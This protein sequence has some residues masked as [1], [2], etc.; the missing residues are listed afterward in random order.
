MTYFFIRAFDVVI[1]FSALVL[2]FP[3]FL[4]VACI[5][6]FDTGSPIFCQTRMGKGKRPFTLIKFRT[7][8][9]DTKSVAT[10]L[11]SHD[12]ITT[13]GAFLRKTKIDELP[14]LINVL[15][16]EMSLVG[17]RPNLFNQHALI[18]ERDSRNIY[19][20]L[21]GITGLSQI[22]AIDMSS[23]KLLAETDQKMIET[24][25]VCNY[26]KYILMTALGSG[27]GDRIRKDH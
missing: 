21:P 19:S 18:G 25:S 22:N 16:G 15:R 24:M 6:Y 13:Y 10:H 12:S 5:G 17:P 1:A 23:P 2:G 3:V 14:Q 27:S 11:A 4:I 8:V 7:M 26:F 9:L 20:A